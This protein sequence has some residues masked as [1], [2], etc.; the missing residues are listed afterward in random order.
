[1]GFHHALVALA[2]ITDF[3]AVKIAGKFYKI[4]VTRQLRPSKCK[5]GLHLM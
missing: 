4:T 1:M 5:G 2:E 3:P